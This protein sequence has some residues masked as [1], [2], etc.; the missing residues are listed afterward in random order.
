MR[1]RDHLFRGF[2]S[3][4]VFLGC[5]AASADQPAE[6]GV[7]GLGSGT[8]EVPASDMPRQ[9]SIA[10]PGAQ[11]SKARG[12]WKLE[13]SEAGQPNVS[14]QVTLA[15]DKQGKPDPK[16]VR[17]LATVPASSTPI[18]YRLR[19]VTAN[20]KSNTAFQF[21]DEPG[22]RLRLQEGQRKVLAFNYGAIT[23]LTVPKKDHRRTSSCYIHPVWGLEGEVLSA[24]FPK[25]HFH[26]HGIFWTWPYVE[27][28]GKSYDLW[29]YSNIQHRFLR[30]LHRETGPVAAVLGV[31]SGWFVGD[32]KVATERVWI[33]TYRSQ[34]NSRAID[35]SLVVVAENA[36][37]TL[38]G[39][40]KKSYG[41]LAFRFNVWPRRDAKVR[42]PGRTLRSV[43]PS[44]ASKEDLVNTRLP[45]A[46]LVT[47]VPG[48]AHRS[49]AAV[50]IN[51]H[52]PDYPPTWLTRAYGVL[53]VGWPGV[54]P[55]TLPARQSIQLDYRVWVHRSEVQPERIQQVYRAFT[56]SCDLTLH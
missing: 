45:W 5:A 30:W 20:S 28:D 3:V 23:D 47:Q 10:L 24:D 52:H 29:T 21:V 8:V 38:Q 11:F 39:R 27:I 42:V 9:I 31:E 43:G 1:V 32:K 14:A 13:N 22:K 40:E 17:L 44:A 54:N 18:R 26:H 16:H 35:L 12:V 55:Y 41:G 46:D 50:F 2:L 49:G 7:G 25:D 19:H 51:P 56:D 4:C 34:A 15:W 53:C 6:P 48:A 37:V 33:T 36:D